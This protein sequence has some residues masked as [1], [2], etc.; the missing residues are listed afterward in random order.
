[1]ERASRQ[2]SRIAGIPAIAI[3][4]ATREPAAYVDALLATLGQ[5][6]PLEVY[7]A[8]PQRVRDVVADMGSNAW[9]TAPEDGEWTPE[10]V[11]GHLVDV[12]IVYG[13]RWRLAVTDEDPS[14]PGYNEKRWAMLARPDA[15]SLIRALDALRTI[16][17]AL[18]QSFGPSEWKQTAV[19][20]EQGRETVHRMLQ[21]IAGHD[22]AHLNQLERAVAA[23]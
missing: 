14:Y 10:Q 13:F 6:D 21:K 5:R 2:S 7:A 8:T 15:K 1:M 23:L 12:D 16:N 22:I 19:H 4:D 9:R 20:G 17:V 11:V 3:P 18:L